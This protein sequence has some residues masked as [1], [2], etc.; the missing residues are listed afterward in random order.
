VRNLTPLTKDDQPAPEIVGF[1]VWIPSAQLNPYW[2]GDAQLSIDAPSAGVWSQYLGY[3]SFNDLP[4]DQFVRV[5]FPVPDWIRS[6]LDQSSYTD[7]RFT[8]AVNTTGGNPAHYLDNFT[9]GP[10][11]GDPTCTP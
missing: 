11:A 1:D 4:K 3:R 7:L 9:L 6:A 8:I 5:E 2:H 10:D